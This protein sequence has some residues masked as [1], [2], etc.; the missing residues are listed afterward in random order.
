MSALAEPKFAWEPVTPRGVAVFAR[1]SYERLLVVQCL[2][3]ALATAAILWLLTDGVFPTISTAINHLPDTGALRNASLDWQGDDPVMLAE[4]NILALSVDLTHGGALR[5]PADFQLEFGKKSVRAFSLL[6]EM[7]IPYPPEYI[8][9]ANRPEARPAWRAWSPEILGLVAASVFFGLLL[10]WTVL[11]TIYA[12]PVWLIAFFANRDLGLTA[13]WKLAAAALL[14]GALLLT[15][16]IVAYD[17]GLCDLVQLGGAFGLH[18]VIGWIYLF[19]SP[20]FLARALPADKK[21]PFGA[22]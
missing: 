5:S 8:V 3:A 19:V 15:L 4:G 12:A 20:L 17:F 16:A 21:N 9:A 10:T 2:V 11:A 22:K 6:G 13:S 18:F 1:A 7:E 14:P